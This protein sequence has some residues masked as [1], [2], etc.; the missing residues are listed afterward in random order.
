[1]LNKITVPISFAQG[2]DSKSDPKQ[3]VPGKLLELEN[4]VFYQT[5]SIKKRDGFD[6]LPTTISQ[7]GSATS[8]AGIATL[9]DKLIEFTGNNALG[10]TEGP[11]Q[12]SLFPGTLKHLGVNARGVA[13]NGLIQ[14]SPDVAY[15]ATSGLQCFVWRQ[16]SDQSEITPTEI[17]YS[18]LDAATGQVIVSQGEVV[19]GLTKA[20]YFKVLFLTNAFYIF[21]ATDTE[22]QYRRII[23]ASQTSITASAT[24]AS[25]VEAGDVNIG[26]F[27]FDAVVANSKI[28]LAYY[29]SA[30][31]TSVGIR[32]ITGTTISSATYVSTQD[33]SRAINITTSDSEANIWVTWANSTDMRTIAYNAA[34][35]AVTNSLEVVTTTNNI[36]RIAAIGTGTTTITIYAEVLATIA[37]DNF[38]IIFVV[39]SS[40][41]T[42]TA[43]V[44]RLG[45]NSKVFE[46]DGWLYYLAAYR[47]DAQT[48]L[49]LVRGSTDGETPVAVAKISPAVA[50][51]Y[52]STTENCC[53]LAGVPASSAGFYLAYGQ[54]NTVGPVN[55]GTTV[56]PNVARTGVFVADVSF[57]QPASSISVANALLISGGLVSY[58]DGQTVTEMGFNYYPE[59]VEATQ[60]A[61]SLFGLSDGSYQYVAVYSWTDLNGQKHRSAPSPAG[62]VTISGGNHSADVEVASLCLTQKTNVVVE[63]YRTTANGTTFYLQGYYE[64][65]PTS[66]RLSLTDDLP[67]S[68]LIAQ[69]VLYTTGGE[70]ENIASPAP[71]TMGTFKNRAIVVPAEAPSSFWYSKEV[72]PGVPVE[73]SDLFVQNIDQRGGGITAVTQMDDKLCLFKASNIFVLTGDGPAPSG[74]NND[75]TPA[76]LIASDS[77]CINDRSLV[78]MPNGVMY[79]SAKG[80]YLLG[81]NLQVSYIGADVEAYNSNVITA[82]RLYP[83]RNQVIFT[84]DSGVALVYDYAFDQ[85]SV[86]TGIDAV[87]LAIYDDKVV[88]AQAD[89]TVMIETPGVYTDNGSGYPLKVKTSWLSFAGLQGFQRVYDVLL[90]GEYK[91]SH[92]LQVEVAHDFVDVTDQTANI[93]GTSTPPY[94]YRLD[95]K[96][97]KCE[98]VQ[99]TIQDASP[100]G[101]SFEI[102][103]MAF[104]VGVKRGANKL[105]QT[106]NYG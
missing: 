58:F 88:Y 49:F 18:V 8:A 2:L 5:R 74:A 1:M 11:N 59:Y 42:Q 100:T 45:I 82:A 62:S 91:S 34:L 105:S 106:R 93:V 52:W 76:Q 101:E 67:N 53:C 78:L 41:V 81:R 4:G 104:E 30:G 20:S 24:F 38:T 68:E 84:L 102:S 60:G 33:A 72:I 90:L 10:F 75:F 57:E 80:I 48:T 71:V 83:K 35:S 36:R 12:W 6:D 46:Y 40:T 54:V 37:D 89:G 15:D 44:R 28:Y 96:K 56:Q 86:F 26:G 25:D 99:L 63:L 55:S 50:A 13:T 94:Q 85:W 27:P 9:G 77:G 87:G 61:S 97:Q 51:A 22:I 21:Y 73:F 17:R 14:D 43:T 7:G 23:T 32:T 3:V 66:T 19:T 16:T 65:E 79:Q 47:G 103:S 64:N 95:F 39:D 29:S 98:A 31:T 69:G 70:V 92:T